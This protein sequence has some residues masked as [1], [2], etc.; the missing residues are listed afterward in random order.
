M[1][2]IITIDGHPF[3]PY[4]P[5]RRSPTEVL[6]AAQRTRTSL[7]QRRSVRMF[8]T[9]PVSRTVVEELLL[10]ASTAPSGAHKQ[11]WTFVAVQDTSLKAQIRAAA[12]AEEQKTYAERMSDTWREAL[13]PLGTDAVKTHLTDAPWVVIVFAQKWGLREDG[14]RDKHYYVKESVGIATGMF[15]AAAH[16][17]GLAT[18]T[19][20]PS[21]MG[22]LGPL[23]ERPANETA[24]VVMPLGYPADDC[25]VPDLRRKPLEQVS[26]IL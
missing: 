1:S 15:I 11:P 23:L 10:A 8:S 6:H 19:H 13:A 22:F 18:L 16:L 14:Q 17:A 5:E 9:D 7:E 26:V 21:P 4:R 2:E 25:V 20:T 12:E 3:R 24:Y